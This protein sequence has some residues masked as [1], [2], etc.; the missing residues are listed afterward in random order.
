MPKFVKIPKCERLNTSHNSGHIS[1]PCPFKG[2][3]KLRS[4]EHKVA[5][6]TH[7]ATPSQHSLAGAPLRQTLANRVGGSSLSFWNVRLKGT[8]RR[9]LTT[10]GGATGGKLPGQMGPPGG[11]EKHFVFFFRILEPIGTH[12]L[13]CVIWACSCIPVS[14]QIGTTLELGFQCRCRPPYRPV[15]APERRCY[16]AQAQIDAAK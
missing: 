9:P 1:C 6:F 4:L 7:Y 15:G 3:N 11:C 16:K 12:L 5:L 10:P 2:E 13:R 14:V 8:W